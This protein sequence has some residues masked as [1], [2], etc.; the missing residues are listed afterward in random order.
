MEKVSVI[1][2]SYRN[3]P[4]HLRIAIKSYLNQ[5]DVK[6]ELILCTVKDDSAVEIA[7]EFELKKVVILDE[8]DIYKQINAG[9]EQATGRFICYASGNDKAIPTKCSLEIKKLMETGKKVCYSSFFRCDENLNIKKTN[10]FHNYDHN[11]HLKGN[12]VN[13]C[14]MM[15]KEIFKKYGPFQ[16][17]KYGNMSH[18]D[19]WLRVFEGEGNVFIY[20][21]TPTWLYRVSNDSDH[22]IR[23][24]DPKKQKINEEAKIKM[25]NNHQMS[26]VTCNC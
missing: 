13:D 6:V 16:G 1:M 19:F 9:I 21:S 17:E 2:N 5:I 20:N 4:D 26:R 23:K 8:P 10:H 18:W 11:K 12:F 22:I 15:R 24:T 14:A 3:N 7:N 25:L